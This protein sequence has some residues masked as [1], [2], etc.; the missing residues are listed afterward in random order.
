MNHDVFIS[1][2]QRVPEPTVAL[3]DELTRRGFRPWYDVNLLPGQ[4]FGKVIDDAIDRAKAVVSIW[5]QPAL[6]STWVPAESARAYEQNK[7]ICV[8]T[9][10]VE[11]RQLP[12]PFHQMHVSLWTEFDGLV[13]ALIGMGVRPSGLSGPATDIEALLQAAQRDWRVVPKDDAEAINAFLDL[14]GQFAMFRVMAR[15]RLDALRA[16]GAP[17]L[18]PTRL[19]DPPP[20]KPEDVV[21]RL[22]P[23]MHTAMIIRIDVSAD[24]HLLATAS[25]DKTVKLWA[26][27]EGR[28]LRTLRPPI[29]P[30]HEGKVYAVALD[31]TGRWVAAAGWSVGHRTGGDGKSFVT[32]FDVATG[33]V[34][35]LLGPLPGVVLD[36]A[37]SPDGERLAAG[38]GGTNG[39]RVWDAARAFEGDP[40]GTF[41]DR[42]YGSGVYGLAFGPAGTPAAGRLA[43]TSWDGHLRLYSP[44]GQRLAKARAPGGERPYGIAFSP[45][46]RVLAMGYD[47]VLRVDML[48]AGAL[49]AVG[50]ANVTGL[51]GGNVAFVAFLNPADPGATPRLAAGGSHGWGERPILVWADA[52]RGARTTWPGPG[53]TLMDLA[54]LPDGALAFGASDPAFGLIDPAGRQTLYRGPA[55][56]DLRSKV[57]EH[58][59]VSSDGCRLRCGIRPFSGAPVLFDLTARRLTDAPSP[60]P[61]LAPANTD[62]LPVEG[63]ENTISPELAGSP[64]PLEQH[65]NARSLAIAPD[66]RTFVLGASWSLRRFDATGA[67]LWVKPVP[68][69]TWGVNLAREGRLILAAYG[70]GTIRWHRAEDGA[71]LL[72]LFIHLP[73]GADGP[74]EWI[75]FTP[76]GYYD[77]SSPEAEKLIGWHVNRGP[78][79][80]ADFY[81]VETF[82]SVYKNPDRITAAL[83][84]V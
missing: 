51:S 78:D 12:T 74:R 6:T 55:T 22:D 68:S 73:E 43:A 19:P 24:G 60:L 63:W 64:L 57:R 79:E 69:L 52:G 49:G 42:E 25:E 29:G 18:R 10:D 62:R 66:A 44:D 72:A 59:T 84:A 27:P 36:L 38:L 53:S 9:E 2:S 48:D 67:S 7:L 37:V 70:D 56:A 33:A 83:A 23:G 82:A 26:L 47:D 50:F 77:A 45:D 41:E 76:E 58:F 28:L 32:L 71:E 8:R 30:G 5:S 80:A 35:T 16:T 39:V 20:V 40:R 61:D 21:L 1:Y 54:P 11:P 65:E 46:G 4:Y 81:P 13:Q 31:P 3:A 34:R 14:Y 15:K 17:S 75:L